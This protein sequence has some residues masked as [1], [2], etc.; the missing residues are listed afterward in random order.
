[1]GDSSV[2]SDSAGD[3]S[4]SPSRWEEPAPPTPPT[5]AS[6]SPTPPSPVLVSKRLAEEA[7][8]K[9][10]SQLLIKEEASSRTSKTS[11]QMINGRPAITRTTAKSTKKRPAPLPPGHQV[12]DLLLL[13]NS[14]IVRYLN[15]LIAVTLICLIRNL[16]DALLLLKLLLFDCY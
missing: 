14:W 1:M 2:S 4:I 9:R 13:I 6:N 7:V 8:L 11:P 10:N 12:I 16:I 15:C 3:R 5:A